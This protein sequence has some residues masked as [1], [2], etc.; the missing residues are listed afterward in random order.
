MKGLTARGEG[1][2]QR[3]GTLSVCTAMAGRGENLF[4]G[5]DNFTYAFCWL[6]KGCVLIIVNLFRNRKE[7]FLKQEVILNDT[8][9]S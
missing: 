3:E 7:C 9:R 1:Q 6:F 8:Q 5:R 2:A 4:S